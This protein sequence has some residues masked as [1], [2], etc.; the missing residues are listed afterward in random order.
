MSAR[1][2]HGGRVLAGLTILASMLAALTPGSSAFAQ[3]NRGAGA[4]HPRGDISRSHP[5][6]RHAPRGGHRAFGRHDGRT[7]W[8]WG[9]GGAWYLYP[10]PAYPYSYAYPYPYSWEPPLALADP[11]ASGPPAAPPIQYW[12][13]CEA[14]RTY[15]PYVQT[16]PG[17]WQPV[18]AT[19]SDASPVPQQ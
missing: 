19:P 13:Y 17:G 15:Y 4:P 7:G 5:F 11:P 18:A 2:G 10:Y 1:S 8:W 6:D 9:V 16:C 14:S 12:Y 3:R